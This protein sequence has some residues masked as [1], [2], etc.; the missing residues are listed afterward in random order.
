LQD[1]L[2]TRADR[3]VAGCGRRA[4]P[5]AGAVRRP[6]PDRDRLGVER[7]AFERRR[8]RV[9]NLRSTVMSLE[10]Y[11]IFSSYAMFMTGYLMLASTGQLHVISLGLFGIVLGAGWLIDTERISWSVGHR[12]ANWMMAGGLT[13]VIGEWYALGVSPVTVTLHFV[14]FAAALKLLRRK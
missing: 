13:F 6:V 9:H 1:V 12:S 14:F 7:L 11:F 4:R 5:V 10:R 3:A 8:G 2:S